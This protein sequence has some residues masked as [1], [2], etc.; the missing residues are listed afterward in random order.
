MVQARDFDK[1]AS[2]CRF[3]VP[4]LPKRAKE[5]TIRSV[6][7]LPIDTDVGMVVEQDARYAAVPLLWYSLDVCAAKD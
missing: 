4:I 2:M 1:P 6:A 5:R 7:T 3:Y